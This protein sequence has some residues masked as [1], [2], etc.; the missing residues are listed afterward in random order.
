MVAP[1][2]LHRILVKVSVKIRRSYETDLCISR[3]SALAFEL[4]S[5]A[6]HQVTR[7][8]LRTNDQARIFAL[9]FPTGCSYLVLPFRFSFMTFQLV[10]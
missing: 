7:I 9:D 6:N 4:E 10:I 5:T 8:A 1:F 2:G 3:H